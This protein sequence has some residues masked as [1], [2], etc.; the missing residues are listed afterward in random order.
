MGINAG[1]KAF[2]DPESMLRDMTHDERTSLY[3]TYWYY[4]RNLQFSRRNGEDWSVYLHSRELYKRT[5]LIY[6]PVPEINDFYVDNIWQ[7]AQNPDYPS[8]VTPLEDGTDEK[9][10]AAVAQLDQWS[11]FRAEMQKIKRYVAATGNCLV[12][13]IDDLARQKILHKANWPGYVT[14]IE[15]NS[16]GDVLSYVLE[17]DVYDRQAN[18]TYRYKKVVN[19]ENYSYF[20][21]DKPFV[22]P[23]KTAEVEPNIYGFVFAVWIR[24]TDDGADHGLPACKNF[25]K[26]DNVN[27]LA[28]HVDD[29]MHK[30]IES[31]KLIGAPG[32]I[33]PLIGAY[34][35]PATGRVTPQDPSL[36]WMVL[37]ANTG[38]TTGGPV[39]VHDL[40]GILKL[41]DAWPPLKYQ[42]ESFEKDYPELQASSIIQQN[43]QLSGAA[44]ERMLGPA[45]NRLD[46]A[47]AG[48]NQQ[49][50]KLRQMQMAVGGMRANGGGWRGLTDQQKTFRPFN[51]SSYERGE[52]N[53]N[54]K[55]SVLVQ[56]TEMED[57][58]LLLKKAEV[59][60]KLKALVDNRE[61]LSVA[62]YSEEKIDEILGRKDKE[63]IVKPNTLPENRQ[64]EA[65]N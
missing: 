24:H 41:A 59:A 9:V 28:S 47:Q 4:H 65:V 62:G 55:R 52:M 7:P 12:E 22:P 58:E 14:D 15:L 3:Q 46:G 16:T 35:D 45:Q 64:L 26:V 23:G 51:L 29:F 33:V 50:I 36:N 43:S 57:A 25:D 31:P 6:N 5:R 63:P 19:Q 8:L 2:K 61:A 44:L 34:Q 10:V 40:S 53:F 1:W 30:D 39:S 18:Q 48:Y 49:L 32:E 37:K 42:I 27:S 56:P 21:D 17:Y 13:G 20:R 60:D 54:L 38:G 11:N